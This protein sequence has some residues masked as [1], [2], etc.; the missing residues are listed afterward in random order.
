MIAHIFMWAVAVLSW[1]FAIGAIQVMWEERQTKPITLG[2]AVVMLLL[3]VPAY[4][5][6][7]PDRQFYYPVLLLAQA[8]AVLMAFFGW[9]AYYLVTERR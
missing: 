9:I 2:C 1:G 8:N 7:K 4:L 3:M 5:Q 6:F